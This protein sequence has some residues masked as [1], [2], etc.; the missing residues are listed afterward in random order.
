M[1]AVPFRERAQTKYENNIRVTAAVLS[2]DESEAMFAVPLYERG[3]QPVWLEIENKDE[4]PVWFFPFGTDPDYFAPLEVAYMHR[5]PFSRKAN[6]KMELYFNELALGKYI[7]PGS[8]RSGFLF[9]TMDLGTKNINVDLVGEDHEVRTFTFFINVPGLRVDH[10]EV[11]WGNLY[12]KDD[13]VAYE[14]QED[15]RIALEGLPCCTTNQGGT[16]QGNPLNIVVIGKGTDVLHALIQSGWDETETLKAGA[17]SKAE[18]PP[19]FARQ[20]R[21]VPVNPLYL[22]GRSQ[23]AAFRKSREM[24]HERNHLRL[25]LSPMTFE[26]KPVWVGQISREINVKYVSGYRLGADVDAA[27]GDMLQGL[28]HTQGL[29]K[30]GIVKGVGS[31]LI[32]QPRENLVGNEYFTDGMRV[33]LWV[34]EDPI[35]LTEVEFMEWEVPTQW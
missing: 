20:Y 11:D 23:D 31:A 32:S 27:R 19:V 3:I 8:V 34:S 35:S 7:P 17:P 10:H 13:I 14:D 6:K 12:A 28:W 26:G 33:V 2:P 9:T 18:L 4:A 15:F 1:E 16:K 24:A 25:W 30:Y 29:A 22:Y 21:Y 5:M